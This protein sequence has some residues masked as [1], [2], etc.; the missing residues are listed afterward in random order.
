MSRLGHAERLACWKLM[1]RIEQKITCKPTP[2]QNF[3]ISS[4]SNFTASKPPNPT[5][6]HLERHSNIILIENKVDYNELKSF[7]NIIYKMKYTIM[8]SQ[9]PTD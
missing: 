2:R 8:I 6:D 1:G 7:S 4:T 3:R 5:K 9:A